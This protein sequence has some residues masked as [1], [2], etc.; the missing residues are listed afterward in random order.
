VVLVSNPAKSIISKFIMRFT[1]PIASRTVYTHSV[2][3]LPVLAFKIG[4][5]RDKIRVN[6][7]VAKGLFL[8]PV[9]NPKHRKITSGQPVNLILTRFGIARQPG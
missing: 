9:F 3:L 4:E 6:N 2:K 7:N 1:V 8:L 5:S